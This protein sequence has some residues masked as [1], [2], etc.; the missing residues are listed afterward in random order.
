MTMLPNGVSWWL[1]N[2]M[3]LLL[4]KKNQFIRHFR[5]IKVEMYKW[6][7]R[8][9][10]KN[11]K[12]AERTLQSM[13]LEP[14]TFMCSCSPSGEMEPSLIKTKL[15]SFCVLLIPRQDHWFSKSPTGKSFSDFYFKGWTMIGVDVSPPTSKQVQVG[16]L[17]YRMVSL[18]PSGTACLQ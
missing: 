15:P 9:T 17:S 5:W 11:S 4:Q 8:Q 14:K 16:R 1:P 6:C 13:I 7:L 12:W 3:S 18:P 2:N 10:S